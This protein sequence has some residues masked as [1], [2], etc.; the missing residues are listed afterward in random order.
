MFP[1]KPIGYWESYVPRLPKKKPTTNKKGKKNPT[2]F[3]FCSFMPSRSYRIP[4]AQFR[5]TWKFLIFFSSWLW[6]LRHK[7]C[8]SL[9]VHISGYS[10]IKRCHAIP[11]IVF[12][13]LPVPAASVFA[14]CTFWQKEAYYFSSIVVFYAHYEP[15]RAVCTWKV[16]G[17]LSISMNKSGASVQE[18]TPE[19]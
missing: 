16:T 3:F 13:F 17:N 7:C 5:T 15:L 6:I 12:L 10:E 8:Q 14:L 1:L 11:Q 4:A 9:S 18:M 2:T 19:L